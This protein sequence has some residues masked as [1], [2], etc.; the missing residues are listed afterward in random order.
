MQAPMSPAVRRTARRSSPTH[1]MR[2]GC[3]VCLA[4]LGCFV[5]RNPDRPLGN[6]V[7]RKAAGCDAVAV[8]DDLVA[9]NAL[10]WVASA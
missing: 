10:A 5:G 3:E 1:N 7:C 2:H 8:S 6:R 9:L 4:T